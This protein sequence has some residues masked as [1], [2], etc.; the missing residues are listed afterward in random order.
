MSP[1]LALGGGDCARIVRW[2]G[3]RCLCLV[4]PVEAN[5]PLLF[6]LFPELFSPEIAQ[7]PIAQCLKVDGKWKASNHFVFFWQ[8]PPCVIHNTMAE[9]GSSTASKKGEEEDEEEDT[10]CPLFMDGLPTNFAHNKHLAAIASLLNDEEDDCKDTKKQTAEKEDS[11]MSKVELKS[12][13]G[14]VQRKSRRKGSSPYN[15]DKKKVQNGNVGEAQLF[16]NLWKI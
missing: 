7:S 6:S 11:I 5:L 4:C 3:A 16:L 13:G 10:T 9:G 12:G 15:K 1:Y 14:K 8:C 2:A